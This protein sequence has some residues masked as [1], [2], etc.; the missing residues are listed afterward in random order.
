MSKVRHFDFLS[1]LSWRYDGNEPPQ[2]SKA[3]FELTSIFLQGEGGGQ[4]VQSE[5]QFLR[6]KSM[7]TLRYLAN[8]NNDI[9]LYYETGSVVNMLCLAKYS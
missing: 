3:R 5:S 9:K 4:V 2:V 6:R 7:I 8:I 1:L